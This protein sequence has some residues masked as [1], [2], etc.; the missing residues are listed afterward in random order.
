MWGVY[1]YIHVCV[2]KSVYV[3]LYFVPS[4]LVAYSY[5][6]YIG[7]HVAKSTDWKLT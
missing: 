4:K 3:F 6:S 2:C 7:L 1:F 5:A